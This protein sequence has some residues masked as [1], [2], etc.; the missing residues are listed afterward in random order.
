MFGMTGTV[1]QWIFDRSNQHPGMMSVIISGPGTHMTLD[2]NSLAAKV[3]A[4]V[5][6]F[7]PHMPSQVE[8]SLVIREKRAT[9]ACTTA[10]QN[11]RLQHKTTVEG[12]WLAGDYCDTGYPATLEGAIISGENCAKQIHQQVLA[13][14]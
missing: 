4:E 9:F 3:S 1:S 7:F 13:T 11:Q 14:L 5:F 12:L 2:N 8:D 6:Q 10:I